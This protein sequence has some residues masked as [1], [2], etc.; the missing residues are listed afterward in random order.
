TPASA[1][2]SGAML[3]AGLLG[4]LRFLPLGAVALPSHGLACAVAGVSAAFLA[5]AL[6]LTQK[7]PKT[8]LA[9]SSVS[10]MGFLTATLGVGLAEPSAGPAVT[11]ALA[12]YA[13]HHGLAK[14]A[15]FLGTG[16]AKATGSGRPRR[17]VALGLGLLALG[18]AGAPLSSGALAKIALKGA[19][20]EGPWTALPVVLAVAAVG[21]TLIMAHFLHR[22]L[23][24]SAG[25]LVPNV[26]L[27]VPW[28]ALLVLDVA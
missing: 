16:V 17:L 5:A 10:Q 18:I 11:L 4:W 7:D 24:P 3:K 22:T 20:A 15:L 28:A 14:G 12:F 19:A 23:P 25:P 9:Y 8:I 13:I 6:G 2:L 21:S 27:W 1:V 26:G